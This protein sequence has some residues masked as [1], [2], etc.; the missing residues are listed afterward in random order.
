MDE[1]GPIASA[2]DPVLYMKRTRDFYSAHGYGE[3]YRWASFEDVPFARL[4]RP[5]P[6]CRVTLITTASAI[7]PEAEHSG[8]GRPPK[9]VYSLESSPPP[10][11]LYTDDVAWHKAATHTADLDS[12][13]PIHRL[14][15]LAR[16]GRIA[17]VGPRFHGVPT[18]Y[19]QRRT[20]DLDAPQLLGRC[21]ED[22]ADLA[23][24]VPL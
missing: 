16:E 8:E 20:R 2:A 3:P 11:A 18:D 14:Q 1:P 6:E 17:G 10:E 5:L 15:E 22:G 19:S 23:L 12:Y 9:R 21:R 4:E 24:L 13:F 7:R